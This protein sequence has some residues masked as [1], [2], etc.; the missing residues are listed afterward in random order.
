MQKFK[1]CPLLGM[2]D[3]K[4]L[5]LEHAT[6]HFNCKKFGKSNVYLFFSS[7]PPLPHF[8]ATFVEV[9]RI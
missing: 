6:F 5:Q 2:E 1:P 8:H 4:I 9:Y 7:H 3:I